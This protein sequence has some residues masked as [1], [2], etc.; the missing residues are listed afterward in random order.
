M[1]AEHR[2]LTCSLSSKSKREE[3]EK[4]VERQ[5]PKPKHSEF[6]GANTALVVEALDTASSFGKSG[7]SCV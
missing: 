6:L 7:T 1:D 3:E 5:E 4:R 2:D